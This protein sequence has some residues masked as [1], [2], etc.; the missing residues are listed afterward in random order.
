MNFQY[1]YMVFSLVTNIGNETIYRRNEYS[2]LG[3]FFVN[4][5]HRLFTMWYNFLDI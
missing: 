3:H 5:L 1:I 2:N 4:I